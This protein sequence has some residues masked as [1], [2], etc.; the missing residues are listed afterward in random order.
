MSDSLTGVVVVGSANLDI[1][2]GIPRLPTLG[3]TLLGEA[4]GRF[5]G[6]KGLNQAVASARSGAPTRMCAMVGDDEAGDLLQASARDAGVIGEFRRTDAA[7]TGVAHILSVHGDNSILV[8]AGANGALAAADAAADVAGASVVLAQLEVPV[9]AVAAALA[10]ARAAGA[11]TILNAAPAA[12]AALALLGDADILVVNETEADELGGVARL[13]ADGAAI[14]IRT[15]GADGVELHRAGEE[16]WY[17]PAFPVDAVDTTGAGD[18]FCGAL[19]AALAGGIRLADA[20]LRAAAAGA[21]VASHRGA[22][23]DALT[24]D[25]IDALVRGR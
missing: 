8:A 18:A 24:P 4:L 10:A 17:V 5:P 7:P 20:L 9:E 15:L 12:E 11:L 2:V 22:T 16:P 3:E 25:T 14:V 23:T 21:I 13:H 19:A 6:G 1:V